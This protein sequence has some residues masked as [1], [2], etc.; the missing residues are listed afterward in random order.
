[1]TPFQDCVALGAACI[2]AALLFASTP[3]QSTKSNIHLYQVTA[4][5]MSSRSSK[6]SQVTC[7]AAPGLWCLKHKSEQ[8]MKN[9]STGN[10]G[11]FE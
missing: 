1:M 5:A 11:E 9:I 3:A 7:A 10:C 6:D 8:G 2:S 4:G